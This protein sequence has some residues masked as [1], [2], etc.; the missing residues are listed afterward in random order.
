[1]IELNRFKLDDGEIPTLTVY[2]TWHG[3]G[4]RKIRPR[5]QDLA[6]GSNETRVET[7]D[8]QPGLRYW[9]QFGNPTQHGAPDCNFRLGFKIEFVCV[10]SGRV[11]LTE[12][13]PL[14]LTDW[15][16]RSYGGTQWSMAEPNFWV[17]GDSG[18]ASFRESTEKN[19]LYHEG[20]VINSAP[21][22]ALS[23]RKFARGNWRDLLKTVPI[24]PGDAIALSFGAWD[25][26][27]VEQHAEL[28]GVPAES[29]IDETCLWYINAVQQIGLEYPD[30]KVIVL[31]PNAP[32]RLQ[33][34]DQTRVKL[35]GSDEQRLEAWQL[36]N[37][38]LE[39]AHGRR[40]ISHYWNTTLYYHDLDGF[41]R[42]ELMHKRDTHIR[43]GEQVLKSL[44]RLIGVH[45]VEKTRIVQ[46]NN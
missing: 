39:E 8:A 14:L 46:I 38:R 6:F 16:K 32:S 4:S 30:C 10:E 28:K 11:L 42:P 40:K 44:K 26:R 35:G 23:A 13:F 9:S 37:S 7:V 15:A 31:A 24:R 3:P 25:I 22:L 1:M 17:I 29:I 45:L 43:L 18:A 41:M 36:F 34:V 21:F 12:E 20:W 5:V 33:N 27:V 19:D 2:W